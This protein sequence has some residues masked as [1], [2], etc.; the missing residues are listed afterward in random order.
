MAKYKCDEEG[1]EALNKLSQAVLDGV[2]EIKSETDSLTD[3]AE[4]YRDTLGPHQQS[5]LEALQAIKEAI[6]DG[7]EPAAAVAEAAA[8][9]AKGYE[10]V[11]GE[12]PFSGLG[13]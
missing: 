7:T 4:E 11:I 2:D 12:D 13:N 10:E 8:D 5:L 9:V 3:T 1:V 6:S